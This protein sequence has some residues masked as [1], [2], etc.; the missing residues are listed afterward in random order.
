MAFS[1]SDIEQIM[2][3]MG[4]NLLTTSAEVY[5]GIVAFFRQVLKPFISMGAITSSST[6]VL[7]P[8]S[9]PTPV[10]LTLLS[11]A[12]ISVGTKVTVDVDSLAET[13]TVQS[14]TGSSITVLLQKP[15]SAT[16]PVLIQ[17]TG[18]YTSTST[19]V[20]SITSP[21]SSVSIT[22]ADATGFVV[23][24]RVV[25]DT[26]ARQETASIQS[27][28]GTT[29]TLLLSKGHAG[30]YPVAVASGEMIIRG[31]MQKLRAI[32]DTLGGGDGA[33][34]TD[35]FSGALAGAGIK[36]VDEIEFFGGTTNSGSTGNF[37]GNAL[38]QVIA[39]REYWRDELSYAIGI[40]RLNG[41]KAG[42]AISS[43]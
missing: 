7:T 36:K 12:G 8:T 18:V 20:P 21:P 30:T 6:V 19:Q 13:C 1:E 37:G 28:V 34:G 3:E 39:L 24:D 2:Y 33:G 40:V 29:M 17:E 41:T 23:G 5:V 35:A 9:L 25:I 38:Q 31:I 22:V 14:V 4:Y 15:H 27:I 16:Y 32:A 10:S 43:Y 42:N 11:I 26:D